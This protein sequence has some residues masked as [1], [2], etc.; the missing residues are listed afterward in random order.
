MAA[1]PIPLPA[2]LKTRINH[3]TMKFLAIL[4]TL[5]ALASTDFLKQF[6]E[7]QRPIVAELLKQKEDIEISNWADLICGDDKGEGQ[8]C[9]YIYSV[10]HCDDGGFSSLAY[11][12]VAKKD[13]DGKTSISEP[14]EIGGCDVL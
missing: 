12:F 8:S 5:P 6:S 14:A 7:Q 11:E 3:S 10:V 2:T 4:F 9:T 1:S 13:K